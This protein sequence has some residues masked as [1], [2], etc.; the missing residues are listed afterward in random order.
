MNFFDRVYDA[1]KNIPRGRVSSYGTVAAATGN[2]KM[3]RQVGWAL[4]VNPAPE[5]V[6]CHRVVFKDGS[7]SSAFAFGG[8]DAQR[9]LLK[10]EGVKFDKKG[11]VK[12]CFFV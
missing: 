1:V 3:A 7:L 12:P 9:A 5:T 11:R 4:H 6:P 10:K 2:K 8:A